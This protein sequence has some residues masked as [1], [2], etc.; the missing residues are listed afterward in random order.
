MPI[1]L[2]VYVVLS[3]LF[4]VKLYCNF[5]QYLIL[6]KWHVYYD[7]GIQHVKKYKSRRKKKQRIYVTSG[8]VSPLWPLGQLPAV[9]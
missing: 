5:F 2:I 9:L 3:V 6:I 8:S 1:F 4:K 7:V